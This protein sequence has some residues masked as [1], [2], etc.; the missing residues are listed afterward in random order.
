MLQDN[1]RAVAVTLL[2]ISCVQVVYVRTLERDGY[3]ALQVGAGEPKLSR[4]SKPEKARFAA[5]GVAPKKFICEFRVSP[6]EVLEAGHILLPSHF[7]LGQFVD[8]RGRS[9]GKGF[10]GVVKRHNFSGLFATHGVSKAERSQGSTGGCQDPGRVFKGK[11]MAGHQGD[12]HVVEQNL[13]VMHVDDESGLL[14]VQ[15]GI[16]GAVGSWVTVADAIK[17]PAFLEIAA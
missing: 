5:C 16:P 13:L 3:C 6:D 7:K 1:G 12:E 14:A 10:S 2:E 8:V 11:K 9:I 17:K 15:G 4:V